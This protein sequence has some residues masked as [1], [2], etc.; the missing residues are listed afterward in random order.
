M[1]GISSRGRG[2]ARPA[3][4]SG[5]GSSASAGAAP[6]VTPPASH[7]QREGERRPGELGYLGEVT[8]PAVRGTREGPT[9]AGLDAAL[10]RAAHRLRELLFAGA[11][12]VVVVEAEG[13]VGVLLEHDLGGGLAREV[14]AAE[15]L[16]ADRGALFDLEVIAIAIAIAAHA[17]PVVVAEALALVDAARIGAAAALLHDPALAAAAA[18]VGAR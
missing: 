2:G 18:R 10:G 11:A 3:I 8:G 7:E 1:E 14:A 12:V 6:P 9:A 13:I 15:V 17:P 16:L 4:R 5:P